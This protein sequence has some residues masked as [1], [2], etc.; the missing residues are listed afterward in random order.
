MFSEDTLKKQGIAKIK[1]QFIEQIK[2]LSQKWEEQVK[3]VIGNDTEENGDVWLYVVNKKGEVLEKKKIAE[4][5]QQIKD[6]LIETIDKNMAVIKMF[7]LQQVQDFIEDV[8]NF[9]PNEYANR[10]YIYLATQQ[11]KYEADS[12]KYI[13]Y[14]KKELRKAQVPGMKPLTKTTLNYYFVKHT[15]SPTLIQKGTAD[16]F[17]APVLNQL[18]AGKKEKDSSSA[19]ENSPQTS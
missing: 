17:L 18:F 4:V 6:Q 10:L 11:I 7:S 1:K 9:H 13:I 8:K 12:V 5:I 2:L 14:T 19:P 16:Q 3:L 15:P